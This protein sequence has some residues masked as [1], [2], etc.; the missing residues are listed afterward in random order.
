MI[1]NKELVQFIT[2]IKIFALQGN[3]E[4]IINKTNEY[5]IQN[6]IVQKT[7]VFERNSGSWDDSSSYARRSVEWKS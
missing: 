5:I 7:C 6:K 1:L 3:C 4:A 2:D